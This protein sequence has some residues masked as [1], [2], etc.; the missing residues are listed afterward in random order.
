MRGLCLATPSV[1]RA[2][3]TSAR[4]EQAYP[5]VHLR[6]THA[7]EERSSASARSSPE[8]KCCR[9]IRAS[10]CRFVV[11]HTRSSSAQAWLPLR[12]PTPPLK[13][14]SAASSPPAS[15][16]PTAPSSQARQAGGPAGPRLDLAW[17]R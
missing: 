16:L 9:P 10:P 1:I 12:E 17:I 7:G 15:L 13:P 6:R 5:T 4:V 11:L 2:A 8:S 3:S 14:I